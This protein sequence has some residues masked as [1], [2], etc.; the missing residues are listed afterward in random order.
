MEKETTH[1]SANITQLL[2]LLQSELKI[3]KLEQKL[4]KLEKQV[5][6]MGKMLTTSNRYPREDLTAPR[7]CEWLTGLKI[8][9]LQEHPAQD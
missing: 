6:E 9:V 2:K 3:T 1:N 7:T 8:G 4:L 5:L